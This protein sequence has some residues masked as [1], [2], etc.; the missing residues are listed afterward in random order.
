M[1]QGIQAHTEFTAATAVVAAAGAVEAPA[2][3]ERAS[4]VEWVR[5]GLRSGRARLA[6]QPVA[7]AGARRQV[8]F[9]EAL[10][11]I[12]DASGQPM[13]ASRFIDSVEN[14]PLIIELDCATV[15]MAVSM[16]RRYPGMRLS[17]NVSQRSLASDRWRDCLEMCLAPEPAV[18][19]RL[20]VELTERSEMVSLAKVREV[21]DHF[22]AAGVA[23]ALDDF[24]AG[25][26][27]MT[28]LR[29]L[30]FDFVKL[31]GRFTRG[32]ATDP[33]QRAF[34]RSLVDLARFFGS[35]VVAEHVETEAEA[36][37]LAELGVN[38]LQGYLVGRPALPPN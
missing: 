20:I 29:D 32:I 14:D 11:R 27:L 31:D 2:Q 18:A 24:G 19:R 13:P 21:M 36:E 9:H 35:P 7:R 30:K 17:I 12:M 3:A 16:L 26:T 4:R 33:A 38:F 8:V 34:V 6:L 1:F 28:Q 23:F 22:R 10:L 5:R 25:F 15:R 37:A